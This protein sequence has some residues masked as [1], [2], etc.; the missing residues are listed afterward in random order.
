MPKKR[1][2]RQSNAKW[3]LYYHIARP[4]LATVLVCNELVSCAVISEIV[5]FDLIYDIEVNAPRN[6]QWTQ[7]PSSASSI[8]QLHLF[9]NATAPKTI[10]SNRTIFVRQHC[11]TFLLFRTVATIFLHPNVCCSMRLLLLIWLLR[12]WLFRAFAQ[13]TSY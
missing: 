9:L 3:Y 7:F 2:A 10:R 4:D 11:T 12:L 1:V 13:T 6:I 5:E 8:E